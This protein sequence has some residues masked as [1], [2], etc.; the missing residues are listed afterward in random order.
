[1]QHG[2]ESLAKVGNRVDYVITHSPSAGMMEALGCTEHNAL[3]DYLEKIR[4]TVE[5]GKWFFGHMHDNTQIDE[6]EFLLYEQII[7]II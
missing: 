1:M 3:T 5:Y 7:K 2:I 6:K 4:T